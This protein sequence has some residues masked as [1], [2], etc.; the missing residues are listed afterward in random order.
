MLIDLSYKQLCIVR[1]ALIYANSEWD[2]FSETEATQS[3][4]KQCLV[5]YNDICKQMP[6]G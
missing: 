5:I 4:G 3:E 2:F 1:A 6:Q